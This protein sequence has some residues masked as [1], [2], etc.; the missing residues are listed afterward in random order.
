[1]GATKDLHIHQEI[2]QEE[3]NYDPKS[4]DRLSLQENDVTMVERAVDTVGIT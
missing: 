4:W 1:M 2:Q 3:M